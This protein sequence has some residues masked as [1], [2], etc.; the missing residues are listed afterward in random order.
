MVHTQ[1]LLP[2]YSSNMF[3]IFMIAVVLALLRKGT[4]SILPCI[5]IH[6]LVK[7][8]DVLSCILGIV[9]CFLFVLAAYFKKEKVFKFNSFSRRA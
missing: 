5:L 4:E 8:F 9:L 1:T 3:D 2:E 6:I 7:S